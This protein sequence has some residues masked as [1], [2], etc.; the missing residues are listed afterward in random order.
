MEIREKEE[1]KKWSWWQVGGPADYFCQ[2]ENGEEL[3]EALLWGG[4]ESPFCYS[5]RERDQ[6]A[7]QR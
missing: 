1:L 5:F 7:Y 6:C 3:Q 4:R 2:P